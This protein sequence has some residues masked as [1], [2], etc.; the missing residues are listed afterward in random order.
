MKHYGVQFHD[1]V[2]YNP[3]LKEG[4][5]RIQQPWADNIFYY[6]QVDLIDEF[7]R[8]KG[9]TFCELR[10]DVIVSTPKSFGTY[11]HMVPHI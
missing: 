10:P 2:E 4:A 9:W 3:P 6:A 11:R 7:S 1:K 5:P 8:N